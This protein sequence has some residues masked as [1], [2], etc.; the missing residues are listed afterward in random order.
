MHVTFRRV[1]MA[2][3]DR[4]SMIK[5]LVTEPAAGSAMRGRRILVRFVQS[6]RAAQPATLVRRSCHRIMTMRSRPALHGG[7]CSGH[8]RKHE[9]DVKTPRRAVGEQRSLR[10]RKGS[11][12]AWPGPRRS[13][14]G[15]SDQ[16]PLGHIVAK[17][18]R[19]GSRWRKLTGCRD[20]SRQPM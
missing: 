20:P 3:L 2:W 15:K 14:V 8:R 7:G 18:L 16:D 13:Q 10:R 9:R 6:T 4:F 1:S 5:L 17:P 11:F 12:L 19:A